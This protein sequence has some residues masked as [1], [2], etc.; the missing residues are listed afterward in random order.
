MHDF[1]SI[2]LSRTTSS[3]TSLMTDSKYQS[4]GSDRVPDQ[5]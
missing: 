4:R 1:R 2:A 5:L 3:R